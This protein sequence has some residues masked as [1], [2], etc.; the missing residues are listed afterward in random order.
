[1]R[2]FTTL[3]T[4]PPRQKNLKLSLESI[5]RN[6]TV[7]VDATV[8]NIC[9]SYERFPGEFVKPEDIPQDERILVNFT[10]DRGP[11][12]KMMG[13]IE[14]YEQNMISKE[15]QVLVIHDDDL[16]Y[17]NTLIE[18]LTSPI[19][20]GDHDAVTHLYGEGLNLYPDRLSI[21]DSLVRSNSVYPTLPGYL[22][23][24]LRI[25]E[26]VIRDLRKYIETILEEV[27]EAVYHDDAVI[28][29]YLRNRGKRI[30]WLNERNVV[31][32]REDLSDEKCSL[33]GRKDEL[34]FRDEVS[35]K[36]MQMRKLS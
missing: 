23:I 11:L 6:Q 5:T 12:T 19:M 3:A 1:M 31:K 28:S 16:I 13:F 17:K 4:I 35:Y 26:S 24:S 30:L 33:S 10:E 27:P 32:Q 8:L 9:R 14:F 20:K 15:D 25:N 34:Q 18:S 29:S 21:D 22:G 2:I 7:N 36:I